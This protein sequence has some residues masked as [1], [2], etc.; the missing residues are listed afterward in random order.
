MEGPSRVWVEINKL[1]ERVT[2]VEGT[3][4]S[5]AKENERLAISIDTLTT[6]FDSAI[7][8]GYGLL[9]GLVVNLLLMIV[10][11]MQTGP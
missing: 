9:G 3:V 4:R 6:K 2:T 1:R 7:R 11:L 10:E 8:L 5:H